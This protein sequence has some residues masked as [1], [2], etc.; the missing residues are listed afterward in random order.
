MTWEEFKNREPEMAAK[1][2]ERFEH[3]GMVL[4]GTIR[5]KGWPRISAVEMLFT[6]GQL[7]LGM[8]WQSKK[9]LDLLRDPRCTV[10][11][12]VA[13]RDGSEGEFKLFGR[14][15][16]ISDLKIRASYREALL[17]K[18]GWK[19]EEPEFHLF[20]IDIESAAVIDFT[21]EKMVHTVWKA[22]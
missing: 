4:L 11:N 3:T 10:H 8:M 20:A 13:N 18:I 1:G 22:E 9:A 21:E 15:L 6:D 12:A 2:E 7:Y 17:E 19:L 16:E 5:K 14:A